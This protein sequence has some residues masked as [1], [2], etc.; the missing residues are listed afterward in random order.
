MT[1][2]N[3]GAV[4]LTTPPTVTNEVRTS[5]TINSLVYAPTINVQTT[6]V[7][8]S[9]LLKIS[10]SVAAPSTADGVVS[11]WACPQHPPAKM[12]FHRPYLRAA[13]KWTFQAPTGGNTGGDIVVRQTNTSAGIHNSILDLS[14]LTSFNANVDQLLIGYATTDVNRPNGTMYLAQNNTITLNS[15]GTNTGSSA[16]ARGF[17]SRVRGQ[18]CNRSAGQSLPRSDQYD[19]RGQR[20]CRRPKTNCQC[21]FNPAFSGTNPTLKDARH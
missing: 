2:A 8:P 17:D 14:G 12:T 13:V 18:R 9:V 1:F 20:V 6:K 21:A 7:D 5:T 19:K 10:G 3:A 4:A 16:Y 15:T 11:F